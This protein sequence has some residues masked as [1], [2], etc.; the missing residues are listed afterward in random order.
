[1]EERTGLDVFHTMGL[2]LIK[3]D[4]GADPKTA[5]L[6]A[7]AGPVP[8]GLRGPRHADRE[9][10]GLR[11]IVIEGLFQDLA[12]EF[13][14]AVILQMLPLTS[15]ATAEMDTG[16]HL[17]SRPRFERFDR[18]RTHIIF[19]PLGRAH[20]H[21]VPGRRERYEDHLAL[22]AP[23]TRAAINQLLYPYFKLFRT[24]LGIRFHRWNKLSSPTPKCWRILLRR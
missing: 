18:S 13:Q 5:Y 3:P 6:Y 19:L 8:E 10:P 7:R 21:E 1:M 16:R 17:P 22:M 9:S 15:A 14:L 11:K 4:S 20:L 12:L 2:G 23:Q 24:R